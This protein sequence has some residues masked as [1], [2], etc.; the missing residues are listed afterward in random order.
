MAKKTRV[1]SELDKYIK[2]TLSVVGASAYAAIKEVVEEE[3]IRCYEEI[4]KSTPVSEGGGGLRDS[5]KIY[6]Y[7]GAETGRVANRYGF[8]IDYDGYNEHRIAYSFIGR[9]LNK[10][11]S[12]FPG[13]RHID[14]A[15]RRLRGMDNKINQRFLEKLE[16]AEKSSS[17]FLEPSNSEWGNISQFLKKKEG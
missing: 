9:K 4:K 12:K 2:S 3:T 10:G 5:L 17:A 8:Y 7:K 15:V 6:E 16:N 13:T 1:Q 14:K 11:T